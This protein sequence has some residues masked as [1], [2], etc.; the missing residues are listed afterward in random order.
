ME[1]EVTIL[2][3]RWELF[4]ILGM[5]AVGVVYRAKDIQSDTIVAVKRINIEKLSRKQ[6]TAIMSE[7]EILQT[8]RHPNIVD[9]FGHLKTK[10]ELIF[11]LEY[12]E[13]G[14][15]AKTLRH[16]GKFP[17]DL[18]ANYVQQILEGLSYLHGK[19]IIHRDIKGD[20]LLIAKDGRVCLSDFG[21]AVK[22]SENPI[23][24]QE[25]TEENAIGTPFWMAPEVILMSGQTTASDIWSLGCAVIELLTGSPPYSQFSPMGAIFHMVQDPHPPLPTGISEDLQQF[26]LRC[27]V[28]DV[29]ERATAPELLL[30][31]WLSK[32]SPRTP[33]TDVRQMR[34]TIS[35]YNLKIPLVIAVD[36]K[37]LSSI[38]NEV[39]I[40][41]EE[42]LRRMHKEMKEVVLDEKMQRIA[43]VLETLDTKW[44]M[45]L[46]R[47]Q[48]RQVEEKALFKLNDLYGKWLIGDKEL[49]KHIRVLKEALAF[50][51]KMKET[52][53]SQMKQLKAFLYE[54][55]K[56]TCD[57]PSDLCSSEIDYCRKPTD[58]FLNLKKDDVLYILAKETDSKWLAEKAETGEH[59]YVHS[60][61][62]SLVVSLNASSLSS[63]LSSYPSS[64]STLEET[65]YPSPIVGRRVE[66]SPEEM[67]SQIEEKSRKD[68]LEGFFGASEKELRATKVTSTPSPI[69]SQTDHILLK[70]RGNAN[71]LQR[72]LDHRKT[73]GV[74][75]SISPSSFSSCSFNSVLSLL[76]NQ[77]AGYSISP[78]LQESEEMEEKRMFLS[79]LTDNP[80]LVQENRTWVRDGPFKVECTGK[81]KIKLQWIFLFTDLIVFAKKKLKKG[82]DFLDIKHRIYLEEARI[83]MLA[84]NEKENCNAFQIS[85]HRKTFTLFPIEE[86]TEQTGK[87][88]RDQWFKSL[89]SLV[90]EIQKKKIL[91][92]NSFLGKGST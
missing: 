71:L 88:L 80:D 54:T 84:S 87:E 74:N 91:D 5:G 42:D 47:I 43:S 4:E 48:Q 32:F 31:P 19:S 34:A 14:S 16:F 92:G 40:Q 23:E 57:H 66:S 83:I 72:L 46:K 20:N 24:E 52:L 58:R 11:I 37:P 29:R 86:G 36:P 89:K 22:L 10:K 77:H 67:L 9:F 76:S 17:E 62:V 68:K 3:G 45:L 82:R 30:H 61:Q 7:L 44:K 13:H 55:V 70:K 75:A 6:H 8:L 65:P 12:M 15:L 27:F 50:D 18:V 85:H 21:L 2:D 59:G 26:L 39:R 28:K 63:S 56:I 51:L 33:K 60:S 69:S 38:E 64:S 53:D 35:S 49:E 79:L 73:T 1:S 25:S 78:S 90:R 81:E 41:E